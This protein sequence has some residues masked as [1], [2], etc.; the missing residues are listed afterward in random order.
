MWRGRDLNPRPSGYEPDE[1]PDCSTPRRIRRCSRI[2]GQV[3]VAGPRSRPD[4]RPDARP[5]GPADP[6]VDPEEVL[7]LPRQAG[8][9]AVVA[10]EGV[11]V[12]G[13]DR[14]ALGG[15]D[16]LD[17]RPRRPAPARRPTQP[18]SANGSG[19]SSS[20]ITFARNRRRSISSPSSQ[21]PTAASDEALSA[22]GPGRR[23]GRPTALRARPPGGRAL[24][25]PHAAR[26]GSSQDRSQPRRGDTLDALARPRRPR[27]AREAQEGVGAPRA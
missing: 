17:H 12:E 19:S 18:A 22:G 9:D 23:R 20:T 2:P 26:P 25:R 14:A 21:S 7:A 3:K 16:H 10:L 6:R 24:A 11:R 8:Q 27:R 15:G 13:G 1:L 5:A 4:R